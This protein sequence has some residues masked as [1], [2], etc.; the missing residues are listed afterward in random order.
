M[1]LDGIRASY[2]SDDPFVWIKAKNRMYDCIVAGSGNDALGKSL[3]L[4]NARAMLLRVRSMG[5]PGRRETSL[6]ELEELVDALVQLD[7]QVSQ[8]RID[9]LHE[10]IREVGMSGLSDTEKAELR[11]LHAIPR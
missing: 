3:A 1:A 11:E 8:Q 5:T 10:R 9:E 2:A 6:G 4:L 7:R